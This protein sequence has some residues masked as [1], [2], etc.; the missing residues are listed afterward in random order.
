MAGL[1]WYRSYMDSLANT[2][3]YYPDIHAG[4]ADRVAELTLDAP[5]LVRETPAGYNQLELMEL[6]GGSVAWNQ[7]CNSS[8]VTGTSGH[9]FYLKKSGAE[10]ITNTNTFTGLASGTDMVIDLTQMI[11]STIADYAYS[12]EQSQAGK[13]IAW[14]KKYDLIDDQYHAYSQGSLES[15]NVSAHKMVGF[16]QWDGTYTNGKWIGSYTTGEVGNA[17][18]SYNVTDFIRVLPNTDYYMHETGSGRNIFY[19]ANKNAIPLSSW[20]ISDTAKVI[21]SPA[22][23]AYIRFTITNAYLSE[24]CLNISNAEKNGTYEAYW[25]ETYPIDSSVTLRGILKTDANGN[26]YYDGDTYE[27]DG[28]V[29]RYYG[30]RAYQA[31]D[32]SLT[33]AI[34]DGTDTVYKLGAPTTESA[35]PYTAVQDIEEGGTEEFVT[36]NNVPV[37]NVSV[38]RRA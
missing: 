31:G 17:N 32:E 37:G 30:E 26:L 14:L 4:H 6:V 13:G 21:T 1:L 16:N 36:G 20:S 25:S 5:Y 10:S 15:V 27:P 2:N 33:D 35:D 34:T 8:S 24:F 28:T 11:G 18:S 38:Y 19:D 23:A 9:K 22:N 29:T 3:G 12:L 7:L